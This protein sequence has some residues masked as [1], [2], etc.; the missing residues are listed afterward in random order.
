MFFLVRLPTSTSSFSFEA[1]T[2][3]TGPPPPPKTI[4]L[5]GRDKQ[6]RELLVY[7]L[8]TSKK[9]K[10]QKKIKNKGME[11]CSKRR[12]DALDK[13][14]LL[15]EES[16]NSNEKQHVK[17]FN[18]CHSKMEEVVQRNASDLDQ[19]SS[20]SCAL[21]SNFDRRFSAVG[22]VSAVATC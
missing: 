1:V 3:T 15:L 5:F 21:V 13:T 17:L 20:I 14:S 19:Q 22:Y 8:M 10:I 9:E 6:R 12:Y 16:L 11:T 2:T 4:G 18:I 7:G